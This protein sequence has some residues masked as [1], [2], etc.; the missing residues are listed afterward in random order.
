MSPIALLKQGIENY[1]WEDIIEAYQLLTGEDPSGKETQ[2]PKKTVKKSIKTS[3]TAKQVV[4]KPV[5]LLQNQT[6]NSKN[7][8]F[9]STIKGEPTPGGGE[10]RFKGNTW[11]DDGSLEVEDKELDKKLWGNKKP[12]ERRAPLKLVKKTCS[13]GVMEEVHP[14]LAQSEIF[15]C[16]KCLSRL[17]RK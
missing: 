13:C 1:E 10:V 2:K 3:K 7:S 11:V 4:T 9:L 17:A 8:E 15:K 6:K 5:K 14:E 12:T 16:N